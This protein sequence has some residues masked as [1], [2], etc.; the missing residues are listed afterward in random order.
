M[1]EHH[2]ERR[3]GG[4][5]KRGRRRQGRGRPYPGRIL[6]QPRLLRELAQLSPFGHRP[7]DG[8]FV[9]VRIGIADGD[10]LRRQDS[11]HSFQLVRGDL[12]HKGIRQRRQPGVRRPPAELDIPVQLRSILAGKHRL[13]RTSNRRGLLLH[14]KHACQ[15]HVRNYGGDGSS[16]CDG[17]HRIGGRQVRD[18]RHHLH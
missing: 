17:S 16:G 4:R 9:R 8:I 14:R 3:S 2:T 10:S 12:R 5:D 7:E 1:D 6:Q 13:H 18:H 11:K 15:Q